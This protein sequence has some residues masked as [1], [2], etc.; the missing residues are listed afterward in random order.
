MT[1][2]TAMYNRKNDNNLTAKTAIYSCKTATAVI[3][4]KHFLRNKNVY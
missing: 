1:V 2:K 4:M 3:Q